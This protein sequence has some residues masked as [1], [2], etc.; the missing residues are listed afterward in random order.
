MKYVHLL[1]S[2]A[3]L[4]SVTHSSPSA[5]LAKEPQRTP[6]ID[7]TDLYHPHQDVGDNVDLVNAYALPEVDLRAVILDITEEH[8]RPKPPAGPTDPGFI[9]VLQLNYIFNRDV[10]VASGPFRKMRS[11]NDDFRDVPSFQRQGI[12]LILK[13][14]RESEQAVDIVSFGSARPIAAALNRDPELLQRKVRM[15]HLC[16]GASEPGF[17]EW[18]VI[19]DPNAIVRLLRSSLPV[20]IYPCAT[21]KGPWDYGPHNSFWRL[22]D[23]TFIKA[24]EPSIRRYLVYALTGSPRIGFLNAMDENPPASEV[25]AACV[26]SHAVWETAVW[27]NVA[28]RRLVRRMDGHYRI[29]PRAEVQPTDVVLPNE[30]RPC[31]VRVQDDGQYSFT[32]TKSPSNFWI[33]DRGDAKQNEQALRE[34]MPWLFRTYAPK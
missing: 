4:A 34:A 32:L 14:L 29:V 1:L 31:L 10:P 9:P 15:I 21:K 28:S 25:D 7:V 24:T 11:P 8:R 12:D 16:A 6:V 23:R 30:L 20:A 22:P 27:I 2:C 17:L 26:K 13:V 19:L 33:Y 5:I 3:I 18:N